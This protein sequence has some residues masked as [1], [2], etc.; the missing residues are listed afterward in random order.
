MNHERHTLR[1]AAGILVG[2]SQTL[3]TLSA[4]WLALPPE[5]RSALGV[6]VLELVFYAMTLVRA[7]RALLGVGKEREK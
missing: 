4:V 3:Q 2:S 6:L 5:L 1:L 7:R